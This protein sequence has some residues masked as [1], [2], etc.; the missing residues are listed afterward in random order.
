MAADVLEEADPKFQVQLIQHLT[1]EKASDVLEQMSP[2]KATD[3]LQE[4]ED[5]HAQ[6]LLDEMEPDAAQDVRTL[7]VHDEETAG[8]IMTTSFFSQPPQATVGRT[9]EYLRKEA[10][11]LDV[12]YYTYVTDEENR[13]LGTINLREL[14]TRDRSTALESVMVR[15]VVSTALDDKKS[16][17]AELFAKYG[18]R[19]LPVVDQEGRIQG[20]IRFKALLEAVAP[21]L[22]R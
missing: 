7:L 21:Q 5:P 4:L 19:A 1:T 3:L 11:D 16:D 8:G 22:R 12:I 20:V 13:L 15:R 14:L 17:V 2:S 9:L 10:A 18:L 6:K